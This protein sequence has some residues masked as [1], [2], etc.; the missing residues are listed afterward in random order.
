MAYTKKN[1]KGFPDTSTP[2]TPEALQNIEDG[3]EALDIGKANKA[4]IQ[5]GWYT[6]NTGTTYAYVSWDSTTKTGVVSTDQDTTNL[7]SVGMKVKFTQNA[8][9]KFG[10][11]TAITSTQITLFMGTDYTLLNEVITNV[12]YS[13]ERAPYGF[14]LDT[15]K[16]SLVFADTNTHQQDAPAKDVTYNLGNSSL[17]LP[18]GN[19]NVSYGVLIYIVRGSSGITEATV[20]LSASASGFTDREFSYTIFNNPSSGYMCVA[21][22][23][24]TLN[25]TTPT[26]YYLIINTSNPSGVTYFQFR[27]AISTTKIIATCAY[28]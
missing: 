20:S 13:M 19:W 5:T 12:F 22:K 3:I 6:G 8:T 7:L 4:D 24:K 11:I 26:T 9:I 2:I 16:W 1:W 28:L 25:I 10:I 21:T 14:P 18:V 15:N 23:N 27:G 17:T